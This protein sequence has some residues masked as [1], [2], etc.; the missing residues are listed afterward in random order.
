VSPDQYLELE[1][2]D[3]LTID[4]PAVQHSLAAKVLAL[5]KPTVLYLMNAG[6]VAIDEEASHKGSAPLAIVE[7]FYPGPRG[8]EALAQGLFGLH[9]RW[10]RL[11]YTIYPK[12]FEKAA[13]SE[14]DLRVSPGR[15]YRYFPNPTYGFGHG[16]S[17]TTWSLAGSAPACLTHLVTSSQTPCRV[18]L[19]LKNTGSLTGDSVVLGYLRRSSSQEKKWLGGRAGG[20]QLM[21]QLRQLFDFQRAVDVAPGASRSIVFDIEPPSLAEA[22]EANGDWVLTPGP[23][24]L[25]FED[26]GGAKV[27]MD[28]QITGDKV[29]LE[30]FPSPPPGPPTPPAP[31]S[32]PSPE[33]D[34]LQSN[35]WLN[36]GDSLTSANGNAVLTMQES[37]GD[38]VLY[39]W[40]E[41]R[42]Q[43]KKI[44]SAGTSGHPGARVVLQGSDGNLVVR[45]SNGKALWS[46]G[47]NPGAVKATLG[48]DCN[49][50]VVDSKS[51][52]LWSTK[53]TC[54]SS[55]IV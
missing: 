11:P 47:S 16:L 30:P 43:Q 38:L 35:H 32:P 27:E 7:A 10:G 41:T 31:P 53:T 45:D 46:S 14:H 28:A 17:L 8:G 55:L 6:A 39:S 22:D 37:D 21:P 25:F 9:N 48:N 15:T 24:T 51:A 12:S 49:F 1:A 18:S 23:L 50:V 26:G 40:S 20:K 44:W 34:T 36:P 52:T 54:A 42:G 3:R 5:G 19:E 33:H 2:H 29:V 13:M 4:L